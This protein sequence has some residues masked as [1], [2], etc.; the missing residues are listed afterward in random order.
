MQGQ[1][2]DPPT[3]SQQNVEQQSSQQ[4]LP[5][6]SLLCPQPPPV[7]QHFSNHIETEL[8]LSNRYDVLAGDDVAKKN[9]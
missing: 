3:S 4:A 8:T 5:Q 6:V 1:Q 7:D 2:P 9:L